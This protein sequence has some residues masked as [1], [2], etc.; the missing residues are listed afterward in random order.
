MKADF[1]SGK[2]GP[3]AAILAIHFIGSLGFSIVIPFLIVLVNDF[4]GNAVVY[5][6]VGSMYPLFQLVGAPLLGDWSD[7]VGRKPVLLIS[8]LGTLASWLVFLAAISIPVVSLSQVESGLTGAFVIT[9]PLL[10]LAAAR[11]LDGLTGGNISVA[12]AY[13]ADITTQ[14]DRTKMF[15]RL[16]MA[17]GLGFILGPALAG[18]LGET[19]W[20]YFPP[21]L[22][23][24]FISALASVLIWVA[25]PEVSQ[26][27]AQKKLDQPERKAKPVAQ[28]SSLKIILKYPRVIY[29]SV[30]YLVLLTAFNI[31]YSGFPVHAITLLG[32]SVGR[33]GFFFA[34]LS[35][36][37][38]IVQ[39]P[40][41]E[42]ASR[43]LSDTWLIL[44]GGGILALNFWLLGLP[45]QVWPWLAA[46]CFALGNG[47]MWPSFLSVISQLV[48]PKYQGAV[49][50]V[51]T[52]AGSVAAVLGLLVGGF[53]YQHLAAVTFWFSAGLVILVVVLSARMFTWPE[54]TTD[55]E[56][57]TAA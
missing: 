18:V 52:S 17:S 26:V 33:M 10:L 6:I 3:L 53:L 31:F 48:Q 39:G 45:G 40:V 15:G 41:L 28:E 29:V 1:F 20:G 51:T 7:R 14:Q 12:Q 30:M 55:F 11:M 56:Q 44:G 34:F 5:G 19:Q 54:L 9:M 35:V 42:W 57:N 36:V 21:V 27:R 24:I 2:N 47:L 13:L 49:Q 50:G 37:M 16:S 4:G 46:V 25:L 32:W 22:A 43:K 38:V 23:A 8:Q